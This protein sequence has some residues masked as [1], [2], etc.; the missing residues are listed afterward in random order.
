[1]PLLERRALNPDHQAQ[2]AIESPPPVAQLEGDQKRAA[3]ISRRERRA[4]GSVS[5]A[6]RPDGGKVDAAAHL[7]LDALADLV[8]TPPSCTRSATRSRPHRHVCIRDTYAIAEPQKVGFRAA[9]DPIR[10][11]GGS[12]SDRR[13]PRCGIRCK[14]LLRDACFLRAAPRVSLGSTDTRSNCCTSARYRLRGLHVLGHGCL[15]PIVGWAQSHLP[16]LARGVLNRL[17]TASGLQTC[18]DCCESNSIDFHVP[19]IV[20][21]SVI[22][23]NPGPPRVQ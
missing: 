8:G 3:V 16:R 6:E 9:P 5:D 1:M 10:R 23:D 2:P 19:D 22:A 7:A 20:W 11:A 13:A 17:R 18:T 12:S 4:L 15:R 21:V 14:D